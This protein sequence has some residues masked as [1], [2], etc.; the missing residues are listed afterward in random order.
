[1]KYP[2]I[3][4]G[5]YQ[6]DSLYLSLT[7]TPE[8]KAIYGTTLLKLKLLEQ[9]NEFVTMEILTNE[10]IFS[11][12]KGIGIFKKN[13][14][15][16]D[17]YIVTNQPNHSTYIMIPRCFNKKSQIVSFEGVIVETSEYNP[18][19]PIPTDATVGTVKVKWLYY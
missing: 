3:K 16:F 8:S 18:T 14:K 9:K 19:T 15:T 2:Q 10:G 11:G 5:V 7:P 13:N 12:Y 4:P 17:L 1:M 6:F